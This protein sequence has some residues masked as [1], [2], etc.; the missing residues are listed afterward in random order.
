[1]LGSVFARSE[2]HLKFQI[3]QNKRDLIMHTN[4]MHTNMLFL[5]FMICL[6]FQASCTGGGAK[7]IGDRKRPD[8]NNSTGFD[9]VG[10]NQVAINN[11]DFTFALYSKAN[12][13]GTLEE[14]TSKVHDQKVCDL[15]YGREEVI[16]HCGGVYTEVNGKN[17]VATAAHCFLPFDYHRAGIVGEEIL[18]DQC[19]LFT[20]KRVFE[21][22]STRDE[23]EC[24]SVILA[25]S[26]VDADLALVKLKTNDNSS[27]P[28]NP[29]KFLQTEP[30]LDEELL[31]VGFP[32]GVGPKYARGKFVSTSGSMF[33]IDAPS[34]NR[35]S[36]SPFYT[37]SGEIAGI[38]SGRVSTQVDF[39][40][41]N[42]DFEFDTEA[43]CLTYRT[44]DERPLLRIFNQPIWYKNYVA[45]EESSTPSKQQGPK[46]RDQK[47]T[48]LK[49]GDRP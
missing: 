4:I 15:Q 13:L 47:L 49:G 6:A 31:G 36:G 7:D 1:M 29:P 10:N 16:V 45:S 24:E 33:L 28:P 35:F 38:V 32:L 19:K 43:G 5:I 25:G 8:R 21:D 40:V 27:L 30:N 48:L 3:V 34:F 17:Y 2:Q 37:Q 23:Y 22:G 12:D 20:L 11:L 9:D 42:K 18:R 44:Y 26:Q 14:Y 41:G 39:E 46:G